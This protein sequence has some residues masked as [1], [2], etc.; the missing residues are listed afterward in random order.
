M[1]REIEICLE[2]SNA[3]CNL[4]IYSFF[5]CE[6]QIKHKIINVANLSKKQLVNTRI[7]FIPSNNNNLIIWYKLSKWLYS[8]HK[9][10]VSLSI[11]SWRRKKK[12]KKNEGNVWSFL[13]EYIRSFDKSAKKKRKKILIR[14]KENFILPSTFLSSSSSSSSLLR[15]QAKFWI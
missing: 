3:Y 6:I 5:F 7:T 8:L 9:K 14:S 2:F 4:N 12:K 10:K 13:E 15:S 1:A 11:F